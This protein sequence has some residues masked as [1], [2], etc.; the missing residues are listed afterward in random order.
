MEPRLS[1]KFEAPFL[2]KTLSLASTAAWYQ[3]ILGAYENAG[4]LALAGA[5][6]FQGSSAF[7]LN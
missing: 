1:E 5:S 3:E 2:I 4:L 7:V 6:R